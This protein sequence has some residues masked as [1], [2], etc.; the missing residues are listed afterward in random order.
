MVD[1]GL[2]LLSLETTD[3]EVT[4]LGASG[5]TATVEET[6]ARVASLPDH[7]LDNEELLEGFA[8]E[9]FE[10]A[11]ASNLPALF[12]E[13][14]YRKRPELLEGGVDA[15]WI[16]L[17]LRRP[18]YKRCSRSFTVKITP[19]MA[20][21]IET[22]EDA[23]LSDYLQDQLGL[24][25]GEDLEAE[26]HLFEVLPGG[27]TADIARYET[28]TP[29]LGSSDEVTLSQFH[30]LTREA[31]GVLL[32]KPGVGRRLRPESDVRTLAAGQR[33]YHLTLGR[34]PLTAAGPGGRR[35][36]RRLVR[37]DVTLDAMRDQVRVCVF[38]S[39]V[40]AQR[41]A[42][43]LRQRSHVG[44]LAVGFHRLLGRRLPSI[45]QGRRPRRLR[46]VHP[47]VPAGSAPAAM[48]ER[49]PAI[50]PRALA[51]KLQQWLVEAFSEFA[52][53]QAQKFLA[54]SED[55]A[56]GVTLAFTIERPPGLRAIGASLARKGAPADVAAA[57]ATGTRPSVRV[58]ALPGYRR[59]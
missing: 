1:A 23:P 4:R 13:A 35:R 31:A 43:R 11:A 49:L 12:S 18:R 36:I 26:V 55:P 28:G 51:G 25:E 5:V 59:D 58:D 24:T 2:R 16:M 33:V 44:T 20:E 17:P 9:A 39:E 22:F 50:V 19:Y 45:L 30:P 38:L 7:V 48:L 47:D 32:G 56:D 10:Q 52:R 29:G 8:L 54:A 14:T 3:E 21:E 15:A 40:K 6:L 34:R 37:L 53:T 57:L 41:L 42:V 46:I 27:T